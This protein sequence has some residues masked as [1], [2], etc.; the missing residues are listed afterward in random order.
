MGKNGIGKRIK[1]YREARDMSQQDLSRTSGVSLGLIQ[2]IEQGRHDNPSIK[3]L[4]MLAEALE[5][6]IVDLITEEVAVRSKK[7]IDKLKNV[8][9]LKY[10]PVFE[11]VPTDAEVALKDISKVKALIPVINRKVNFIMRITDSAIG[12]G[13]AS[14]STKNNYVGI[15]KTKEVKDK[16]IYLI[17][18][19]NKVLIRISQMFSGKIV[20]HGAFDYEP[21]VFDK[22]IKIIGEIVFWS[23]SALSEA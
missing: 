19:K 4:N 10:I 22:S 12:T 6:D 9:K 21:L 14:F 5:V 2:Q 8:I 11:H 3:V 1:T 20:F 17:S 13:L 23:R 7:E 15:Q 16:R 18:Q